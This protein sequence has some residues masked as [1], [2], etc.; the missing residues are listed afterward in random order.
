MLGESFAFATRN[1]SL[2]YEVCLAVCELAYFGCGKHNTFAWQNAGWH[3]K[4][5]MH[6]ERMLKRLASK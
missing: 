3:Q 1:E 6:K 5:L 2:A 4:K